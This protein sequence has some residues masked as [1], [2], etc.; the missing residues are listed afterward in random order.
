[1]DGKEG[2]KHT[3]SPLTKLTFHCK[4]FLTP[5]VLSSFSES[6]VHTAAR[7]IFLKCKSFYV[8]PVSKPSLSPDSLNHLSWSPRPSVIWPPPSLS[9]VHLLLDSPAPIPKFTLEPLAAFW[10]QAFIP[11]C[12]CTCCT[13]CLE[14]S[15]PLSSCD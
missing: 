14:Y 9:S 4:S 13:F 5:F 2:L 7:V 8:P 6:I 12:L 10:Y 3:V 15:L 1:M 11:L